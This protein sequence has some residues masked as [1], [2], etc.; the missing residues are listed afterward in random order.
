MNQSEDRLR[1][2][3]GYDGNNLH[4]ED[5]NNVLDLEMGADDSDD[6]FRDN[7]YGQHVGGVAAV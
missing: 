6:F 5:D 3:L 4:Q 7:G 1:T 2:S